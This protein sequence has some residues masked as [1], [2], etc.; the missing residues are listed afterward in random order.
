[1]TRK[2]DLL[3]MD[4]P[5]RPPVDADMPAALAQALGMKP[6]AVFS[7]EEDLLVLAESEKDVRSVTLDFAVLEKL[8]CR[9]IIVTAAGGH[10]DFVSRFFAPQVGVNEDPVTGSAHC[11]LIP[12]WS[13]KL[14]KRNLHALQ[15]SRRGGELFCRH[16]DKRVL[17]SGRSVLYLEGTISI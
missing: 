4:F 2:G 7:S 10:C 1:M 12:F 3:E 5:A 13:E 11:V 9:G 8:P 15:V 17:I 6:V 16:L 14:G